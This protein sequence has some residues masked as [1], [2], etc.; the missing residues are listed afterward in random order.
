MSD[1]RTYVVVGFDV[2]KM[3]WFPMYRSDTLK[4]AHEA[5]APLV[6]IAAF[7]QVWS[8]DCRI[9][10][11][12][13]IEAMCKELPVIELADVFSA[14][15]DVADHAYVLGGGRFIRHRPKDTVLQ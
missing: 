3:C 2:F 11:V 6:R 15:A 12:E 4:R 10:D 14:M 7:V 8:L 9:E 1:A 13:A 5:A